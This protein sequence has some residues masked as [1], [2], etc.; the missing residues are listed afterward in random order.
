MV[1]LKVATLDG[2]E[3]TLSESVIEEFRGR[4]GGP[5]IQPGDE[6]YEQARNV[7]NGNID[8]RPA[9]IARCLGVADVIDAV[10]FARDNNLLVALR[11]G[12]HNA[13][14]HG[15]CDGGIVIDMSA[16][17]AVHVDPAKKTVRAQPG[18]TWADFDRETL[19]FGLATTGGVVSN[20]GIAGL[21][22]GGGLGWLMGKHGL[23]VDNLVSADVVTAVGGFLKADESENEDIF[24]ALR[25]GGGNFGVVTS[26]EY[27]LHDVEPLVLGGMVLHPLDR[28]KEVLEFYREF[29]S[30]IPDEA[31]A[32]TAVLTSPEGDPV[33]AMLLGYNGPI[34]EGERILRPAREFGPPIA[35]L[36]QPMPYGVRQTL[37]DEGL[38]AHGVQRYW[39][40]AFTDTLSDEL[41][42]AVIEGAKSFVSP[43]SMIAMFRIH[44][45]ATRV[46]TDAT[47]FGL[48]QA[49][50][51]VNIISQWTDPDD[52]EEQIAWTRQFWATM[53]PHISGSTYV[54]HIAADDKPERVRASYGP[55][56]DR[57]A[58]LKKKYDPTNMFRLNPNIRPA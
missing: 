48:R 42:D 24:W 20:T 25:G 23:T 49:Q 16:M 14:G 56:Y 31:E 53:E 43:M 9:L 44:G 17:K 21:T 3:A 2:A 1:D 19:A 36:V 52:N 11:G 55:N 15:T 33:I 7:W 6:A 38:I 34:D 58:A 37:M 35:D 5:L 10:N 30:N 57:L 22:L 41:I 12:A 18:A 46:E 32:F 28:A 27:R 29:S 39:K 54:N 13:A 50:W 40:S 8:K 51:D 47:A 45:A 4:F 26:F